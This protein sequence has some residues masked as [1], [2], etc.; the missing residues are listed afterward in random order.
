MPNYPDNVSPSDPDA[1]WNH[2]AESEDDLD[3][4]TKIDILLTALRDARIAIMQC[5]PKRAV[6]ILEEAELEVLGDN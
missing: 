2:A 5:R 1:P 6:L 3:D 4:A